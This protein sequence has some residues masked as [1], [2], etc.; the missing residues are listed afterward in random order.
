M[1]KRRLLFQTVW[2]FISEKFLKFNMGTQE[3]TVQLRN[4]LHKLNHFLGKTP[5]QFLEKLPIFSLNVKGLLSKLK[6]AFD[7]S[8]VLSISLSPLQDLHV[9]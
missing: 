3:L 1:H 4:M 8:F 6:M 7:S 5:H 9:N 2:L